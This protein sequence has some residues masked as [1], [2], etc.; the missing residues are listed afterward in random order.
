MTALDGFSLNVAAGEIV[1][2]A[3]HNGAGKTTFVDIVSGLIRPDS[4][5]VTADGKTPAAARGRVGVAPQHLGLYPSVTVR[6]HL[7]LF[8]RLA[9][10]RPVALRSATGDVTT[11]LRLTYIIDRRTGGSPAASSAGPRPRR[12]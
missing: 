7:Q 1:G 4:G 2:L 11:S 9:G 5:R 6:E 8:G 12:H 10:L 3:G